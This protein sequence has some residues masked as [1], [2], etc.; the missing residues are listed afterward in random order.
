MRLQ[1]AGRRHRVL[2]IEVELAT[3]TIRQAR[4]HGDAGPKDKHRVILERWARQDG[5]TIGC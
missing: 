1:S 4:R 5:L 3:R 2:T